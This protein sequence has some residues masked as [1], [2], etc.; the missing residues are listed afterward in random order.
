MSTMGT[1]VVLLAVVLTVRAGRVTS[2]R[3]S[4]SQPAP[5]QAPTVRI[6]THATRGV[7]KSIGATSL[8]ITR[9]AMKGRDAVF[10][11]NPATQIEGRVTVGS[12][13]EVR[14][15]IKQRQQVATAIRGSGATAR[16]GSLM[17]V[18]F[19]RGR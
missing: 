2:T 13:V 19:P 10:L 1:A 11:L 6:A 7:V 4:D 9:L 17:V 15:R 5:A 18:A 14:Y 3:W 12:R 8:L 16:D